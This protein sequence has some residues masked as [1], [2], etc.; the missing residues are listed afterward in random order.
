MY[1]DVILPLP[2]AGT[3]TYRVPTEISTQVGMRVLVPFGKKKIQ[4]GII[5]AEHTTGIPTDIEIKD[6]I[7]CLDATPI[8]TMQQLHLWHWVA[9]YYMCTIGEVMKAALPSALKLESETRVSLVN[10]FTPSSPLSPTQQNILHLLGDNK[11][12]SIDEIGKSLGIRSVL[13]ALNRLIDSEAV[14]VNE[15]VTDKYKPKTEDYITLATAYTQEANLQTLLNT[16]KTAKKQ[17]QLL[18]AYLELAEQHTAISKHRLL[19]HAGV[20]AATLKTLLDKQIFIVIKQQ[21]DRVA[22]ATAQQTAPRTL[23]AEQAACITSINRQWQDKDV[24]LL[25]GVTSGGKTEVYIHLIQEQLAKQKQVLYLVPEIAL[26]TQLTDRLQQVFGDR[27]GVYHSRF[28]D[29]ERAETYRHMLSNDRYQVILGVRSS[30]FLPFHNLGLVIIDEE[31]DSSYKQQDPAPRYHARNAAIVLAHLFG[32]KTLLGTAT[33][34]IETYYNALTGKYGLAELMHRYAGM[35]LPEITV[36]DTR[37][38][39]HRKEMTGHF[40]DALVNKIHDEISHNK[41]VIIFQNRRGYA[42]YLECKECAYVPKCVNCDVSLTVHKH[43]NTLVC[44]YCGYTQPIPHRCPAC[45][46]ES[47]SDKGF[48]TEKI[49]DE[50]QQLFPSARIARMDLDTTRSRNAYKRIIN[51][52]ADHKTDILVGT[53]MVSKGLHFDEVSMVAVLNADNLM[54]QP[55]FRSYEKA[56]QMLEQVSGRAGRKGQKGQVFIQTTHPDSSLLQQVVAHDYNSLYLQQIQERKDFRYPPFYRLIEVS[57][58]HRD[59][60]SLQTAAEQLQRTL[61]ATFGGRCSN[62]IVPAISKIQNLYIRQ[63]L[64]KIEATAPYGKAR[65]LLQQQ[66]ELAKTGPEGKG[67]IYIV[68]IDPQ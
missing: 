12:H 60:H 65:Q 23:N 27:L 24:V 11:E 30:V 17:Q 40:S 36:I 13:P 26:T 19:Q 54:N 58:R 53:Q 62:L 51:D 38:Q 3:F 63:I 1:V 4:T 2:L 22:T 18:L 20:S 6:I 31:H 10:D 9:D 39:Y 29:A 41:Q 50:L 67:A 66:I 15:Q 16:L 14:I 68:N 48:G 32:G 8:L 33:P 61:Q 37:K 43:H 56:F 21:I 57:V 52:F 45:N 7:C 44:H 49:E 5:A 55:D 59:L 47:L 64:L 46:S 42:P 25:H 34:A 28:T 35:A